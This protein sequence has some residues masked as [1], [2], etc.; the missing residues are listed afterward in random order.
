M[1]RR[2]WI[3]DLMAC[4]LFQLHG[5]NA[6]T[7]TTGKGGDISNLCQFEW[8]DWCCHCENSNKFTFNR[9]VLGQVLGPAMGAGN[10]MA[11]WALKANGNAVPQCI[12]RPLQD[13]ETNSESEKQ[14]QDVFDELIERRWGA[15][16]NPLT[17]SS[18]VK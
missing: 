4:D 2:A 9:E 16:I 18:K 10:E 15:A 8:H 12:I 3:N 17:Q 5:T 11:Q 6:C 13:D 1:E 7:A 14:K